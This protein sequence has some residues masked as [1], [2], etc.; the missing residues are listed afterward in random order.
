MRSKR[1]TQVYRLSYSNVISTLALFLALGGSAVALEGKN[2][3]DSG[4]VK[5]NTLKSA[6]VKDDALKGVD[7]KDG[8]L[9]GVD[10][11]DETLNG[12]D[13]ELDSIEGDRIAESAVGSAEIADG[14][15]AAADL[16]EPEPF[17]TVTTFGNGGENDCIW[18]ESADPAFGPVSY[19]KDP[20]GIVH[21]AGVVQ[22]ADGP[23]GD[24]VCDDP[25]DGR[26]LTLPPGYRPATPEYQWTGTPMIISPA[27]GATVG[28]VFLPGGTVLLE[29]GP[30]VGFLDGVTFRAA[31]PPASAAARRAGPAEL[32][33]L[34][35]LGRMLGR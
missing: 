10:V 25:D 30:R 7:V 6:D 35:R 21:L 3:V 8:T 34:E 24:G 4:D 22:A 32:P 11:K 12:S 13:I 31:T 16:A 20:T 9:K 27:G 33:S 14:S 1:R 29:P 2:S 23:G 26:A 18:Q 15:V 5:N 19:F 28:G 17:Q